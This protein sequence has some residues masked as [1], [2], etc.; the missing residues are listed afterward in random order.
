MPPK[1]NPL[2]LN[3]LQLKTLT[4]LQELAKDPQNA[5]AQRDGAIRITRFPSAHG[6]H[7]HIGDAAVNASDA[8]GLYNENVWKALDRKAL[9]QSSYPNAIA[10]TPA[11][12]SYDTGAGKKIL[13]RADH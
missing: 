10:L 6:N 7:F 1:E 13:H 12:L 5:A 3:V 11:G 4:L 2:K 9:T 8:S